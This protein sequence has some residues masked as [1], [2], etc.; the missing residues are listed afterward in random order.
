MEIDTCPKAVTN[1]EV[2]FNEIVRKQ[3]RKRL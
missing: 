1:E 2:E 3:R